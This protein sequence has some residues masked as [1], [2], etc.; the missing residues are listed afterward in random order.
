MAFG[1]FKRFFSWESGANRVL[2]RYINIIEDGVQRKRQSSDYELDALLD[3]VGM[4]VFLELVQQL[5]PTDGRQ[6]ATL[7]TLLKKMETISGSDDADVEAAIRDHIWY[8][9]IKFGGAYSDY[10]L[11]PDWSLQSCQNYD[12]WSRVRREALQLK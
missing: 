11:L 6:E 1:I 10:N 9:S 8:R 4:L 5:P 12:K 7:R 3:G 2:F